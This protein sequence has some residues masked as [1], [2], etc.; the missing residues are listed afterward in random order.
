VPALDEE[1][2]AEDRIAELQKALERAHRSAAS[3]KHRT[4]DLIDA[5]TTTARDVAL[6]LGIPGPVGRPPRDR[7]RTAEGCLLHLTD[8]QLGKRT[9]SYD[10]DVCEERVHRAVQKA[11]LLSEIQ[12][13]DHPVRECVVM[14]GGDMVE[15]VGIFPG[16]AW[17]VAENAGA[18]AQL[19][20]CANLIVSAVLAL[21]EAFDSVTVYS[22]TGNHG[23]L[24]RKGDHPR[25]DN[26][27]GM[28]YRIAR[29][30]LNDQPRLT[31]DVDGGWYRIVTLGEYRAL[32]VHGD[33]VKSWGGNFPGHGLLKKANAWAAGAIPE[34]FWDLYVGHL[35]Q[36][37]VLQM[38]HGGLIR[39]SPSTESGSAYAREFAGA[40]GRPG[41]RLVFVNP[42]KGR[43]TADY[44]LDL[45]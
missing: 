24:G 31:W 20:R 25:I 29:D 45:E 13:A 3:A 43:V 40:H 17:E 33:Q 19:F 10:P 28:A 18:Y 30:R 22:V 11:L 38:A 5:V 35:H 9:E 7:R 34:E 26:L 32:L 1:A 6:S 16:Q 44:L 27:D 23:R 36:P 15:G 39:M 42:E 4:A 8:W 41:Q 12:R 14:L 21:L 37:V 2:R